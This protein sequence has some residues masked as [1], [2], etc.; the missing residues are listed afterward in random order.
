MNEL[1]Q[2]LRADLLSRRMLPLLALAVAGLVA[3]VGYALIG[4]GSAAPPPSVGASGTSGKAAAAL[5]VA[6]AAPN[7]NAAEA[8]TPGG[9]R[10]QTQAPLHN[11]FQP[12]PSN[13]PK[14]SVGTS[15]SSGSSSSGSSS[16]SGSTGGGSG[17]TGGGSGS[18][19][20][21]SGG[22]SKAKGESS[23]AP[24]PPKPSKAKPSYPYDVSVLF[25]KLPP[26]GQPVTLPPYQGLQPQQPLPSAKEAR[27]ALE[28][29]SKDA[30]SAVFALLQPP[31]LRGQGVCLPSPS[32]CQKLALEV[33]HAA[34]LEYVEPSG[35][36]L[37]YELKTVSI[38]KRSSQA[39]G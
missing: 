31:I 23:P 11:P 2:S 1:L 26:G 5:S 39:A 3:A 37:V 34:E 25:G 32:E 9:V 15:A 17:S 6:A 18:G 19:G 12:L 33:G 29:V 7:P 27:I 38:V 20:S 13:A 8:E 16:G 4:S 14:Q 36:T 21:G 30:K 22:A 24:I 28:R 35:Q 10:Y